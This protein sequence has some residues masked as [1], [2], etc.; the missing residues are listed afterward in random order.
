M[1][2][3]LATSWRPGL[4][5]LKKGNRTFRRVAYP[6]NILL[7][8]SLQNTRLVPPRIEPMT[9]T[10]EFGLDTFGDVT[11]GADGALLPHA[12]VIRNVIE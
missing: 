6:Y 12:Q 11:R 5:E 7:P 10:L 3:G 4:T 2:S 8:T 1:D 9:K